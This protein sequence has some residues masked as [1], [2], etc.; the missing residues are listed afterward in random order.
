MSSSTLIETL[1]DEDVTQM[2]QQTI[3]S[4]NTISNLSEIII[5]LSLQLKIRIQSIEL[6]YS[7]YG[8]Q[9][10]LELINRLSTMY[11]FSGTK[12]LETYLYEI[13]MSCN[14][15]IMLKI[16]AATSLCAFDTK[17]EIGYIALDSV[18]KLATNS[19]DKLCI[20]TPCYIDSICTL[21]NHV[22]FTQ[23][24]RDYFCDVI[25]NDKIDCDYR[26]KTILSLETKKIDNTIGIVF[27]IKEAALDFFNNKRNRTLYRILAGQLLIHKYKKE[28]GIDLE[29]IE[30]TILSFAQD[31]NL[32]YNLRADSAD[33]LLRYGS[34][35]VKMIA[36]DLITILGRETTGVQT[37]FNN[38]QNVHTDEIE[39]SVLDILEFLAGIDMA[40]VG[41]SVITFE[42][43]K[44]QIDDIVAKVYTKDKENKDKISIS[45]N[46]IFM[47]RAL[48][49][50][51]NCTILNTLLKIW[52]YIS[53]QEEDKKLQMKKRL[54]E[55]LIDMSGTCSTG[56]VSRLVNSITGFGQ[57][58]IRIS[59]QDQIVANFNGRLNAIA[60]DICINK[61]NKNIY[62][63]TDKETLEE[64]QENVITEMSINSSDYASRK[65]FLK[66]FRKNMLSIRQELY[67]EFKTHID[68]ATFDLYCIK[69][70]LMYE[71]GQ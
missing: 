47:D 20:P 66:F 61:N 24:A 63:L 62:E 9:S 30:N 15:S 48:Y 26:Y 3:V 50:K 60:R 16:L 59:W 34:N 45:L 32:D 55:E 58:S 64:F 53:G 6:F 21:M 17:K 39:Q 57:F 69:A 43:V 25:N 42:Y 23:N 7:L 51:Y 12:N 33:V 41:K 22:K 13:C 44:K 70:C 14:I 36:K 71:N 65:N 31:K 52:T 27:F 37:V 1:R 11:Q 54:V 49:S 68:D 10:C 56:F 8:E 19:N 38:A 46:R 35:S 5:D 40:I 28:K 29:H 18:C 4:D 67:N 2:S